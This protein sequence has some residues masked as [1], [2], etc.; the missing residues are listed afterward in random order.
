MAMVL[1]AFAA[2]NHNRNIHIKEGRKAN[3]CL[4]RFRL[5]DGALQLVARVYYHWA[6]F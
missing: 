4:G 3:I 1:G 6:S 2:R 5:F